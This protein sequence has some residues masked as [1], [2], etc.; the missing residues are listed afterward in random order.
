MSWPTFLGYVLN[1]N[2]FSKPL[3]CFCGLL[4]TSYPEASLKPGQDSTPSLSS[5][6]FCCV[7]PGQFYRWDVSRT[8]YLKHPILL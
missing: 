6:S 1:V 4:L 2:Y 3:Q 8:G 5:Q 7:D